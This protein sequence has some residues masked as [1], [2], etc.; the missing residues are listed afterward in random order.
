M[1]NEVDV[2][3]AFFHGNTLLD[4]GHRTDTISLFPATFA[5]ATMVPKMRGKW[6]LSCQVND[7][8]QGRTTSPLTFVSPLPPLTASPADRGECV[9]AG[10]CCFCYQHSHSRGVCFCSNWAM[11]CFIGVQSP[12]NIRLKELYSL[13]IQQI[14]LLE[15]VFHIFMWLFRKNLFRFERERYTES[16]REMRICL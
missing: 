16:V 11:M 7:H 3:S 4:R 14:Q 12:V 1:G 13:K 9:P 5:T 2:H 8:L 6:L 15:N 10:C